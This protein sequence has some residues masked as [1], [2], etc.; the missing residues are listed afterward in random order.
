MR[1]RDVLLR[2]FCAA[3]SCP[4]DSPCVCD[5][6]GLQVSIRLQ[7]GA[8]I[9]GTGSGNRNCPQDCRSN[10][11]TSATQDRPTKNVNGRFG[12]YDFFTCGNL[13]WEYGPFISKRSFIHGQSH[14]WRC[15]A[16]HGYRQD[17]TARPRS[18][19]GGRGRIS[20]GAA[21]EHGSVAGALHRKASG[22]PARRE[23]A[24]RLAVTATLT[25]AGCASQHGH[26]P[27]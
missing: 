19:A 6:W 15:K 12:V 25:P 10:D 16:W 23:S 7:R 14:R 3:A 17:H 9:I 13:P 5:L 11:A 22:R 2:W 8:K 20:N 4:G 21:I 1:L 27:P 26:D 18:E 24:S